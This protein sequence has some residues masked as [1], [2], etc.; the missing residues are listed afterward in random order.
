MAP[1]RKKLY[2]NSF[3]LKNWFKVSLNSDLKYYVVTLL[4]WTSL[5]S[6]PQVG[7]GTENPHP[8]AK[9]E[10]KSSIQGFLLPRHTTAQ[11]EAIKRPATGLQVFD[12]DTRTLWVFNG[13][14]WVELAVATTLQRPNEVS[15]MNSNPYN[16]IF[17]DSYVAPITAVPGMIYFDGTNFLGYNGNSW[18]QLNNNDP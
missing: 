12:L 15:F 2:I 8:S 3:T 7:V 9:L 18:V 11:R 16:V 1:S 5:L 14:I 17:L 13:Q 4:F 10:I 6:F